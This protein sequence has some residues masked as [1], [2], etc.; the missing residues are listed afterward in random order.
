MEFLNKEHNL[1]FNELKLV[2]ELVEY[3][4]TKQKQNLIFLNSIINK[5]ETLGI[6]EQGTFEYEV[7]KIRS[8][9]QRDKTIVATTTNNVIS[10]LLA[11]RSTLQSEIQVIA[12]K[13]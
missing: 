5:I 9:L 10:R 13:R 1:K 2:G 8:D 3:C 12:K 4:E 11:Y 6:T 7:L